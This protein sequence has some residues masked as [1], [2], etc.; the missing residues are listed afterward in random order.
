MGPGRAGRIWIPEALRADEFP[1]S[2]CRQQVEGQEERPFS[3]ESKVPRVLRWCSGNHPAP[4]ETGEGLHPCRG[5][6]SGVTH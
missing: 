4:E 5:G 1:G 6:Q 2:D 3:I